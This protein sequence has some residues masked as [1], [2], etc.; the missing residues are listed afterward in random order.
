MTE[1]EVAAFFGVITSAR[2]S[3]LFSLIYR[4]MISSTEVSCLRLADLDDRTELRSPRITV[5]RSALVSHEH[6]LEPNETKM[7]RAWI[8]IR[9]EAP[10]PLFTTRF[11]PTK[12][13]SI[14]CQQILGLC[15]AYCEEAGIPA[16]KASPHI[17]QASWLAEATER[18]SKFWGIPEKAP[19]RVSCRARLQRGADEKCRVPH[20]EGS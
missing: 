5:R 15:R 14:T 17:L 18:M 6:E 16:E 19:R 8:R 20:S 9:A 11:A 10:G 4:H 13:R 7:M 12:R 3:I 1:K 2:D